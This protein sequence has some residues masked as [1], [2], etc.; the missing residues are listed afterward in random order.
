MGYSLTGAKN[1][2]ATEAGLGY[3]VDKL[4]AKYVQS[5]FHGYVD[6]IQEHLG[7][8]TGSTTPVHDDG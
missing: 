6:P 4:S 5:Y 3:E 1:R 8:L 7:D 2:P